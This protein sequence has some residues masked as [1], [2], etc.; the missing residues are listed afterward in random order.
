MEISK[1]MRGQ[2][3]FEYLMTHGWAVLILA[4]ALAAIYATG[5]FS[6]S[7]YARQECF[8][9]PDLECRSYYLKVEDSPPPYY[10]LKLTLNNGL[11]FDVLAKEIN[12]TTDGVG[13]PGSY[14]W[15]FVCGPGVCS[16]G[17]GLVKSGEE[18]ELTLSINEGASRPSR[19]TLERMAVSVWYKNCETVPGYDGTASSCDTGTNHTVSGRVVAN[20]E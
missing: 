11:G 14:T 4:A 19:G 12:L 18:L 9:Q 17:D 5:V 8:F 20:I 2:S 6:P 16:A 13:R 7:N 3:A 1:S 15:T 10:T